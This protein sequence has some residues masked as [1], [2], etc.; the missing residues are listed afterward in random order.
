MTESADYIRRKLNDLSDEAR[1]R[2]GEAIATIQSEFTLAGQTG[3]GRCKIYVAQALEDGF[4]EHLWR[5]ARF[6]IDVHANT[7]PDVVPMVLSAAADLASAAID[8]HAVA[9][10]GSPAFER[11]AESR[12]IEGAS[13]MKAKL[14][15]VAR[16]IVEDMQNGIVG[17][18]RHEPA[19]PDQPINISAN[20]LV[21]GSPGANVQQGRDNLQQVVQQWDAG[22]FATVLDEIIRSIEEF[23]LDQG[24]RHEMQ[25]QIASIQA[26]LS[27]G[28]KD[29]SIIRRA[30]KVVADLLKKAGGSAAAAFGKRLIDYLPPI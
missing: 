16:L 12:R 22:P 25:A 18:A 13:A 29:T 3:S 26:Q 17:H 27:A 20:N 1:R 7:Q 11:D 8:G 5:M 10:F 9:L 14:D 15:G 2:I 24:D 4:R 23:R 6:V 21:V 30:V 28:T 19:E